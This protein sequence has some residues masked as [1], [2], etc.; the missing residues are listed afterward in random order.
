MKIEWHS[1]ALW[2]WACLPALAASAEPTLEA[3]LQT[4]VQGVSRQLERTLDAPATVHLIGAATASALGHETLADMLNR[5]PGMFVGSQ[6]SYATVGLRGFSRPGDYNARVLMTI[7]GMRVN[8]GVYDQALPALEFPIA[9]PW[10]KRVELVG[11]PAGSV[12]GGN[13]LLGVVNVVTFDGADLPGLRWRAAAGGQ[14]SREVGTTWG[15]AQDDTDV[16]VAAQI[17]DRAGESLWLPELTGDRVPGGWVHGLDG[18]RSHAAMV[19]W[20]QAAWRVTLGSQGRLKDAATAPYGSLAGTPGTRFLDRYHFAEVFHEPGWRNDL[21]PTLRASLVRSRFDGRYLYGNDAGATF[22]NTDVAASNVATVDA[23]LQWRGWVNHAWTVGLEWRRVG[24]A[25]QINEDL[26]PHLVYLDRR[27]EVRQWGAYLQDQWRLG[28]RHTLNLG[29]RVDRVR[30]F[31][32]QASPRLALV[33]R[34][35]DGESVKLMAGRAFRAPNLSER[36]YEDG[37]TQ[38]ANPDLQ[39]E[40]VATVEAGWE[41]SVDRNLRI[42]A[43]VYH[44]RMTDLIDYISVDDDFSQYRNA[45]GANA[46]G[47]DVDVERRRQDGLRWRAS[48]SWV[49][50]RS[51]GQALSNSPSWLLKGHLIWPLADP[52]TLGLQAQAM[53]R[54]SGPAGDVPAWATLDLALSALW[55]GQ[56]FT[57]RLINLTDAK[58][59]DPA[60]PVHDLE[61]VPG[62]RRRWV[63]TWRGRF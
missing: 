36:F 61:R 28:E 19:K 54:R 15:F 52:W 10:I 11:G 41:R 45:S 33:Y 57:V 5:L 44:Y 4:E 40:R 58:H 38:W 23:R 3:L 30:G 32:T 55:G 9:S 35:S 14:A 16:F 39:P 42:G 34:P 22:V 20:R 24:N 17:H 26:D 43:S 56:T 1:A 63:F 18:E 25:R 50:T 53:A 2:A 6:R 46:T 27:D 48:A 31:S 47:L 62:E 37:Y 12:Y 29:L 49:R 21:R 60:W 51:A 13:A 7:D 8:D 59:A